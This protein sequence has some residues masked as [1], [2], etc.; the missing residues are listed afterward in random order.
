MLWLAGWQRVGAT[1]F[2]FKMLPGVGNKS[3]RGQGIEFLQRIKHSRE[4]VCACPGTEGSFSLTRLVQARVLFCALDLTTSIF[5]HISVAVTFQSLKWHYLIF[6]W[7][8]PNLQAVNHQRLHF[9]RTSSLWSY[10]NSTGSLRNKRLF[11][12]LSHPRDFSFL[13]KRQKSDKVKI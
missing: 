3:C 9:G 1:V 11:L 7:I 8:A 10:P 2:W 5:V 4:P 13:Y 6:L 12:S